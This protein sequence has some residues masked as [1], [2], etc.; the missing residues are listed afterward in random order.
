MKPKKVALTKLS[1]SI[2][3]SAEKGDTAAAQAS[4]K[5]FVTLGAIKEAD[6]IP[7]GNYNPKQRRNAGAPTS[8]D[9]EILMGTQK[10]ALYGP[11]SR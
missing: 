7:G 6:T 8:V 10:T 9:I 5:E 1:K 11:N 4:I 3:A 2:L